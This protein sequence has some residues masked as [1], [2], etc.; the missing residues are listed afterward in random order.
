MDGP[1]QGEGF[2]QKNTGATSINQCV[3][4]IIGMII[5]AVRRRG[6]CEEPPGGPMAIVGAG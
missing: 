4:A 3:N 2:H 6:S 1:F 5:V